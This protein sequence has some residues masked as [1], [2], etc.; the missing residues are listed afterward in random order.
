MLVMELI[1]YIY[2]FNSKK[3]LIINFIGNKFILIMC[4]IIKHMNCYRK[5]FFITALL[6]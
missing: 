1:K 3:H 6:I 4:D 5:L 2:K